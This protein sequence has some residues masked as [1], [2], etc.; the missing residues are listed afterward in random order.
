VGSCSGDPELKAWK[1]AIEEGLQKEKSEPP[2]VV[3]QKGKKQGVMNRVKKRAA[4]KTATSVLG[5]KV[6]KAIV[7]EETTTLLNALKRIVKSESGNAKKADDLE[8]KHH[9]NCRKI[10]PPH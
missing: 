8:K 3:A 9:Q 4:S 10:L 1:I 5:K 6:M 7:N 2:T